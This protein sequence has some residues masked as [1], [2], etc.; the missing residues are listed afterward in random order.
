MM[1]IV[2]DAAPAHWMLTMTKRCVCVPSEAAAALETAR[3]LWQLRIH[4][5]LDRAPQRLA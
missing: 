4:T 1:V 5:P 3:R 2:V